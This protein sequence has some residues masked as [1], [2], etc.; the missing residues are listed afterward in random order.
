MRYFNVCTRVNFEKD[1][2]TRTKYY[3]AGTLKIT[4]EGHVFLKLFHQPQ[5]EFYCFEQLGNEVN[6][7]PVIDA[8][9]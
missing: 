9:K 8:D 5:V 1:G 7:L 3:R 2:Q 6:D 4:D